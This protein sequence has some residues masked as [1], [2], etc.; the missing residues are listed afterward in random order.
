M[1]SV[2]FPMPAFDQFPAA[3]SA[4]ES[5]AESTAKSVQFLPPESA[6]SPALSVPLLLQQTPSR[7]ALARSLRRGLQQRCLD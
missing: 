3:E 5:T 6:P 1:E 2:P 7:Y 4:A